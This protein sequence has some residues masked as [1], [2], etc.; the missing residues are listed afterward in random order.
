MKRPSPFRLSIC[1]AVAWATCVVTALPAQAQGIPILRDAE[2]EALLKDAVKPILVA[3][4]VDPKSTEVAIVGDNS[5]NAFVTGGQNIFLNSGTLLQADNINQIIG[6]MAH[7]TG[8]ISGAHLSRNDEAYR[9]AT[10]ITILSL[11]LGA[12][13]IAAGAGSLG[14]AVIGAGQSAAYGSVLAYSRSQEDRADQAGVT[15]LNKAGISG[16]GLIEFF[17]KLQSEEFRSA[18]TRDGFSQDHPLTPDRIASLKQRVEAAPTATKPVD[19]ALNDRFLRAKA[20][21]AGFIYEPV[22]T[23]RLYPASDT[24]DYALYA[25]S[26]AYNKQALPEK[27]N[28]EIAQ[29]VAR[30]P[31]DPYYLELQGQVLLESGKVAESLAP[32][33]LAASQTPEQ[34]LILT[35]F[36]QALVATDDAKHLPEARKV[37]ERSALLDADNPFTWFQ[38]GVVYHRLG[39]NAREALV[40]A[41]RFNLIGEF[42]HALA[43]AKSAVNR[44]PIGSPEWV[45][46]QDIQLIAEQELR[47]RKGRRGAAIRG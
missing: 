31:T 25:R 23:L 12:A 29:L 3:A 46:A 20:K 35:L 44:L 15:F 18:V 43:S 14:A 10:G 9:G 24:S 21:L 19:T 32:L 39:D 6:V 30:H 45:R 36:G 11:L 5:I 4:G 42:P 27:A 41:E 38:L 26:F 17:E 47:K 16:R 34:P 22:Y 13:A 8:H 2:T 37:L 40:S 33:R 1:L 7:E 28:A